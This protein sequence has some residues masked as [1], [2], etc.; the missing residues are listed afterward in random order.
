[1]PKSLSNWINWKRAWLL[2]KIG[3]KRWQRVG[4]FDSISRLMEMNL[5]KLGNSEGP[6]RLLCCS[7]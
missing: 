4:R 3:G 7:P 6:G 2:G 5:S 1:M